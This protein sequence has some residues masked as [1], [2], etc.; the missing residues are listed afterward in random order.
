MIYR[1]TALNV[2]AL[3]VVLGVKYERP[4]NLL[5]FYLLTDCYQKS[6]NNRS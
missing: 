2:L 3:L 5:L 1:D 4:Q 6:Y